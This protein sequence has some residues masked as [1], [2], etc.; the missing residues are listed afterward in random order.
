MSF[1]TDNQKYL[2]N[3]LGIKYANNITL[4]EA[5]ELISKYYD[6]QD[7]PTG[8]TGKGFVTQNS[9]YSPPGTS[10]NGASNGARVGMAINGAIKLFELGYLKMSESD[11]DIMQP[12][13]RAAQAIIAMAKELEK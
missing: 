6:S 8:N 11:V 3:K 1:A 12:I 5:K 10:S 7:V 2:M 13:A 4:Q 9:P